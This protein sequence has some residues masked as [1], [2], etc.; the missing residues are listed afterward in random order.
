MQIRE[1]IPGDVDV[2]YEVNVL[3]F[4]TTAEASL[5]DILRV[6][7]KPCISQDAEDEGRVVGHIMF[8]PVTLTGYSELKIFGLAPMAV[9][10][11]YQHQGVGT[12]L[13]KSGIEECLKHGSGAVVVLGHP[14]YYPRF[15]FR[16]SQ[17]F[18]INSEYDVPAEVFMA[19]ELQP[20]YLSA[21]SGTIKYHAAFAQV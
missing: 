2:I 5:V 16:P 6:S 4:E 21:A 8:T 17:D 7:A 15:G 14:D 20:G 11:E 3:A 9:L 10:P 19:L 12:A 18:S 1:E 13:V